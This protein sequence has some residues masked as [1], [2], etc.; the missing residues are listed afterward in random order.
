MPHTRQNAR[1]KTSKRANT[2][3]AFSTTFPFS[4]MAHRCIGHGTDVV[5]ASDGK[6]GDH[7]EISSIR[8]AT[9]YGFTDSVGAADDTC[10][11]H[12]RFLEEPA[13][14]PIP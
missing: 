8:R 11:M 10:R 13:E 9:V 4:T 12:G 5:R 7:A 1:R 3:L 14:V 2:A 6:S